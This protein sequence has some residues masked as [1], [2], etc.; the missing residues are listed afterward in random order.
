MQ[1]I[2][3]NILAHYEAD[4]KTRAVPISR[5]V[6]YRKWLRY[7]LDFRSK[8]PLPGSKS[9]QVRAFID[10]LRERNQSH[11]QQ[12][13]AAHAA[14]LFFESQRQ[15]QHVSLA[16]AT[17]IPRTGPPLTDRQRAQPVLET[18]PA[19]PQQAE[20]PPLRDGDHQA[21]APQSSSQSPVPRFGWETVF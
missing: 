6:E 11:E 3:D 17:A 8:Y 12:K 13:Q 20:S 21:P 18:K 15:K 7:Y 14:S 9:G 5:H 19:T 10:K 4:L 2:P 16:Q 1:Q